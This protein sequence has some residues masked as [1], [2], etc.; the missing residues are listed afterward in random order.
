MCLI[1][2]QHGKER[3]CCAITGFFVHKGCNL[4]EGV[5]FSYGHSLCRWEGLA[6]RSIAGKEDG[7]DIKEME[8]AQGVK[9]ASEQDK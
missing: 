2:E 8:D 7:M 9:S 5:A 3:P 1:L 6:C 4:K